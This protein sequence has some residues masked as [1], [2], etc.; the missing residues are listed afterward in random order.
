MFRKYIVGFIVLMVCFRINAQVKTLTTQVLVVGGTTGGTA[1]GIQAAR[2]GAN[3]LIIEQTNILGGML[4]AAGVSCTDGNHLLASGIWE[5]LRQALYKHYGTT[6]LESGWVSNTCFE[7][8]VADSIFKGWAAAEKNL[9][10]WYGWYLDK[11]ITQGNTVTGAEFVN[12]SGERIRVLATVTIDATELGDV[13]ANAGAGFYLGTDDPAQ[14]GESMAP[15]KT[16]ILQDLTWAAILQDYG[17]QADKT[18]EKPAGYDA[19]QYNCSTADAPC[20][21]GKPYALH[22]QQ[23]LDYGK[24]TTLDTLHPKY[25]L[26]WPAHG[27]DY[28][29]NVVNS[30]PIERERYYVQA[31]NHTLGFIYFIQTTLGFT[32]IG[33]ATDEL[34]NGLAWVPYNREGRRLKGLVQLTINAIQDPF[35]YSLYRTGIAVG[36]YPVDHHHGKYTGKLPKI[37]FPKIPSF[38]IPLG[39]LIPA[40]TA[41]L[42]VCEKG[43]SVSNI[44]NGTTRLQPV[45]LLTG[46]AA[47]VLAAQSVLQQKQPHEIDVRA[48]QDELLHIKCYLMPYA[49][50]SPADDAWEAIQRTG[51]MGILKGIGISEGWANKTLFYPDS[52][53]AEKELLQGL[54]DCFPAIQV[55]EKNGDKALSIQRA[56]TIIFQQKKYLLDYATLGGSRVTS[57]AIFFDERFWSQQLHL[58]HFNLS[59]AITRKELAVL[60]NYYAGGFRKYK[61]DIKGHIS[62]R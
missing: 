4:T 58:Q 11:A 14:T 35:K 51:A 49:D 57:P 46:Q 34:H 56:I 6:N 21:L 15:G 38:N 7:P 47:G 33:L 37:R 29:L 28:Y 60:L 16:N 20:V 32:H 19:T 62:L 52:I 59:R 5:E 25:M 2:S 42:V 9:Q 48:V 55:N 45:V 61:V 41:G 1:A 10:V 27:N 12:L 31:R 13:Y 17:K 23:V 43:I 22:T 8:H 44:A 3:T 24:L 36:D 50:V 54:H 39:A 30:K 26:N 53:I 40:K 18:I